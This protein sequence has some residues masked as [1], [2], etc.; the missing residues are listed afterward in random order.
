M[1]WM[2]LGD[3]PFSLE[4]YEWAAELIGMGAHSSFGGFLSGDDDAAVHP[5]GHPVYCDNSFDVGAPDF[6]FNAIADPA[7]K[8]V[9]IPKLR[10]RGARFKSLIHPSALVRS[11]NI[12][13]GSF[14]GPKCVIGPAVKI[15][16][17]CTINYQCGIGHETQI[18]AFSTLSPGVQIG[19]R[20]HIGAQFFAGLNAAII[21]KISIGENVRVHPGSV[22]IGRVKSGRTMGG[23]PARRIQF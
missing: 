3:G 20:T 9:L 2:I 19:G 22:I 16:E 14:I 7:I 5:S 8:S 1:M 11:G 18:G 17:F 10:G 21:D 23:N 12:G 13:E 15:G 4:I 6:I